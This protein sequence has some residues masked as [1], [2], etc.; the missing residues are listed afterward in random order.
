MNMKNLVESWTLPSAPNE[1]IQVTLRIQ[2]DDYARLHAL[3]A[4]YP[5]RSVNDILSDIIR[6]GLDEIVS[7]LPTYEVTKEVVDRYPEEADRLGEVSGPA[8]D[9]RNAYRR[10][11]EEKAREDE[12]GK[13]TTA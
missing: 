7:A 2:F 5:R 4:A 8:V 11:L 6:L 9:F 3:K 10:I 1:R 13:E 12:K